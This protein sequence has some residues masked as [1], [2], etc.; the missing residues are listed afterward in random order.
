LTE[1]VQELFRTVADLSTTNRE[2][3][4]SLHATP[5]NLRAEVES[6]LR[7]DS[8]VRIL[9]E[10]N[11]IPTRCGPWEIGRL[12]GHGGM[13]AVYLAQRADGEVEQRAAIKF[14]PDAFATANQSRLLTER[15]I[16]ASL[17]HPGIA[18][19]L[20][21][22]HTATGQPWF[23][24][25]YIEGQP[26]DT[27]CANLPIPAV[28]EIFLKVCDAVAYAHRNLIVHRDLKPSNIL[29]ESNSQPRLLDFGIARILDNAARGEMTRERYLTPDYASPEQV[30]GAPQSTATDVYSLGAV[31]SRLLSAKLN[32]PR[33]IDFILARSMRDEPEQR[34]SSTEALAADIRALLTNQPVAARS[35][36]GWYRTRK[37]LR[38]HW[39]SSAAIAAALI[40]LAAGLWIANRERT[41]AQHRFQQLRQLANRVI[42]FDSDVCALPGSTKVRQ[43]I[44]AASMEYLEGLGR[45]A[46]DDQDLGIDLA[47]GYTSLARIQ[48]LP[49]YAN[50]G[51]FA[52]ARK[53]LLKAQSFTATV[54]KAN[55]ARTDALL[56]AAEIEQGLMMLSDSEQHNADALN[57]A[58]ACIAFLDRLTKAGGAT[59]QKA[60]DVG[61]LYTNTGLA[62]M[63]AH[64]FDKA[65]QYAQT[66]LTVFRRD[67]A[68]DRS[69][70]GALS[71]IA[72]IKRQKGDLDGALNSITESRAL[73]EK[74]KYPS[75]SGKMSALHAVLWRQGLILGEVDGISLNR[76]AAAIEPLQKDFDT[77]ESLAAQ[78]PNDSTSRDRLGTAA[79]TLAPILLAQAE[80]A[81]ALA[82]YDRAIQRLR[83][84][85]R[86][87]KARRDEAQA[88]AGSA[89]VLRRLHRV[90]DAALRLASAQQLL[91]DTKDYPATTI[92][93]G[94]QVDVVLRALAQHQADTGHADKARETY[95]SILKGMLASQPD[96]DHDLRQA[97]D[98][99]HIYQALGTE[100]DGDREAIWK[101]WQQKLPNNPYVSKQLSER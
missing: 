97:N 36:N 47:N 14:V 10:M 76:P 44:V 38:R 24:M 42:E 33:D 9:P 92:V 43:D 98:L 73:L 56:T 16:L 34:Y 28:L 40:S 12:L 32:R 78:N 45:E 59:Q 8:P 4:F 101:K 84:V 17:S 87:V 1:D 37:L 81:Q 91:I 79:R 11:P 74:T 22:G 35:G 15:R 85:P 68:T 86:S 82:V 89:A 25:E 58:D 61:R 53:S 39:I 19:L 57:H 83:E 67:P 18:R 29:V 99:S 77:M 31:L 93:P 100:Y 51:Q 71:L 3:Y 7:F 50:L 90:P 21:A 75:I 2:A 95:R 26:I 60:E 69:L 13:G 20:D 30:S 46:R 62:Y 88:L 6:L 72:N 54:L 66:A 27:Y 64:Q 65:L 94:G 48:G 23:V 41:I 52:E 55:P 63:N 80:P 96:P 70:V 5:A 49:A